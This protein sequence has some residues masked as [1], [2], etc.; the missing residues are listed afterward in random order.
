MGFLNTLWQ[1]LLI[2]GSLGIFIYGMKMMSE[3]VQKL[4]GSRLRAILRSV[5][6]HPLKAIFTGFATTSLVQS[7]S[8]TTVM[9]VSFVNAGLLTLTE[10][11]GIIMGAN[12]GTTLTSWIVNYAGLKIDIAPIAVVLIG[13]FFPLMFARRPQ[14]RNLS[15]TVVG[16][17]ILFIGLNFLKANVPD[18][19]DPSNVGLLEG[20][21][22]LTNLGVLSTLIF[23]LLGALLTVVVQSSSASTAITLLMVANG[24]I[25]FPLGAAMI[26]GENIGTTITAN[27]AAFV[28]NN[29]AKRAARFHL[30][31]NVIG[32]AWM[33]AAMPLVVPYIQSLPFEEQ[34]QVNTEQIQVSRYHAE[35]DGMAPARL[36]AIRQQVR[37]GNIPADSIVLIRDQFNED[38]YILAS[39]KHWFEAAE[40]EGIAAFTCT[41]DAPNDRLPLFHTFFNV[42]NVLLL[43][44]FL[45][46]FS[47]VVYLMIPTVSEDEEE[48]SLQYIVAGIMDT[49]ELSIEEAR[50]ET[51]QMGELVQKMFANVRVLGFGSPKNRDRLLEKVKQRED[52]SDEMEL[53]IA[54]FLSEVSENDISSTASQ[55]IQGL[56]SMINDLERMADILLTIAFTLDRLYNEKIPMT[57][58]FQASIKSLVDL[59]EQRIRGMNNSLSGNQAVVD[60]EQWMAEEEQTD[61]LRDSLNQEVY[62][63]LEKKQ[64]QAL[65]SIAYL[66]LIAAFERLGDHISNVHE[67]ISV[68]EAR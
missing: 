33:F 43:G 8:A 58:T 3:G 41:I 63:A 17:G 57:A 62:Q 50:K 2:I 35:N 19:N 60:M 61:A 56:L 26:L 42:A 65:Q 67:A 52:I 27:I 16:F 1:I 21:N 36:E 64:I 6:D 38:Q 68:N 31:F 13:L 32:V 53:Q 11:F 30:L 25:S 10:S 66:N 45:P 5:T 23:I 46:F 9:V 39:G 51:A 29:N 14:W 48:T 55:R 4:A 24:W 20:V 15:E 28:A 37:T 18:L 12:I 54:Q 40:A 22:A 59:V 44:W 47:R 7:S 49:A 34:Q